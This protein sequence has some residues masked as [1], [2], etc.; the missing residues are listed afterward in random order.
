MN[1]WLCVS[2]RALR[3][4]RGRVPK[5]ACTGTA[6]GLWAWE[7]RGAGAGRVLGG[8]LEGALGARGA[9]RVRGVPAGGTTSTASAERGRTPPP[10]VPALQ[11]GDVPRLPLAARRTRWILL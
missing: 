4:L 7:V 1:P 10:S 6:C 5:S 8:C 11:R 2:P 3:D 9:G